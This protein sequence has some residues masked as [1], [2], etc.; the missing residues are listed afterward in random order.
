MGGAGFLGAF[1][2]FSTF[3]YKTLQLI[4]DRACDTRPGT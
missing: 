3:T 1:T 2:T 4:E